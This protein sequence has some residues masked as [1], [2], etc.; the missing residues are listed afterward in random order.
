MGYP[1][2]PANK[3]TSIQ[4]IL[5]VES[6]ALCLNKCMIK[7]ISKPIESMAIANPRK[8]SGAKALNTSCGAGSFLSH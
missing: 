4:I 6:N 2:I 3:K 1:T 7:K 5:S 8:K